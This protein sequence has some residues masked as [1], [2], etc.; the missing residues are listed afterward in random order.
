MQR[1]TILC[2]DDE[3]HILSSLKRLFRKEN[4]EVLTALSGEEGLEVLR[5]HPVHL[6]LSDQRMPEMSGLEFLRRAKEVFPRTFRIV[7]TGFAEI[8]SILALINEAG[9][10]QFITKPWKDEQLKLTVRNSLEQFELQEFNDQLVAKIE[11]QK[12]DLEVLN[13]ALQEK[14]DQRTSELTF[15]SRALSLSQ[16]I[17]DCLPLPVAGIDP[18]G[19]VVLLNSR[20]RNLLK[21][22][23]SG[24]VSEVPLGVPAEDLFPNRVVDLIRQ[25]LKTHENGQASECWNGSQEHLFRCYPLGQ[26][27]DWAFKGAVLVGCPLEEDGLSGGL[28]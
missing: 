17:V 9:V 25:V 12:E 14:V 1:H 2:V 6:I 4:L 11:E 20:I 16:E 3:S 18:D 10:H 15:R 23:R 7:L 28:P 24:D 13:K 21:D 22:G 27:M 5:Q 19:D 8:D 26:A